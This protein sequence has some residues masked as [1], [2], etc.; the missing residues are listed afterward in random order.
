MKH[1]KQIYYYMKI[2]DITFIYQKNQILSNAIYANNIY[3]L[4]IC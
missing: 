2:T 4:E 3:V 1:S